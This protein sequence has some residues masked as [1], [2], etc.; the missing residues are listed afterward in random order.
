M[1]SIAFPPYSQH[2]TANN[3]PTGIRFLHT[4]SKWRL[5]C[6]EQRLSPRLSSFAIGLTQ[7]PPSSSQII[8]AL[9]SHSLYLYFGHA[10]GEMYCRPADISSSESD[11]LALTW[12][13]GCSSG[14]LRYWNA[15]VLDVEG[16]VLA[17]LKAQRYTSFIITFV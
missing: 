14:K 15:E 3:L 2:N 9:N 17:L 6:Y 10:G 8:S 1:C 7:M 4:Q 12:L 5:D 16:M 11:N 13:M